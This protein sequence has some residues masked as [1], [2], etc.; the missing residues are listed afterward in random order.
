MMPLVMLWITFRV[1]SLSSRSRRR[2]SSRFRARA[3]NS[4]DRWPTS[5]R[6]EMTTSSDGV[7][8]A[9][10]RMRVI[11]RARGALTVR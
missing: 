4:R 6:P 2:A 10:A 9:R 3:L 5:S 11:S 8:L 7:P 1:C